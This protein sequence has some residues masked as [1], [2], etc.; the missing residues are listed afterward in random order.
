MLALDG[1]KWPA[2]HTCCF[3]S[4][5]GG[6]LYPFSRRRMDEHLSQS[7]EAIV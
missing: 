5:E 1:D 4:G 3:I 6:P 2:S 7:G